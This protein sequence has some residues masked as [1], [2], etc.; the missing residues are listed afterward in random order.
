MMKPRRSLL[1]ALFFAASTLLALSAWSQTPESQEE[2]FSRTFTVS[3]GSTLVVDNFKGTIHVA[4]SD[5]KQ[6][7]VKVDKVFEGSDSDRKWW[8]ANTRVKF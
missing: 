7:A 5:I 3:A 6:I 1:I 2:H 8:M 4:G